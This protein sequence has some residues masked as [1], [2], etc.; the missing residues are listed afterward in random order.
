[1]PA[2]KRVIT[3]AT[4]NALSTLRFSN[5]KRPSA[6]SLWASSVTAGEDLTFGVDDLIL[7]EAAEIN[8]ES[9]NQVIDTSRDQILFREPCPP[10][11]YVLN[12]PAV[13]TDMSFLLVQ[14]LL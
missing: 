4:A 8:L 9:A 7:C 11:Q 5:P 14:E 6:V 2:I 12:V 3:A 1:V 10:G 13:A